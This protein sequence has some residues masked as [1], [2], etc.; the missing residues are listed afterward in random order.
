[1]GDTD[2]Y[3]VGIS[4]SKEKI[5]VSIFGV[6]TSEIKQ[7]SG[8][9]VWDT[10]KA[11]CSNQFVEVRT[12]HTDR[13]AFYDWELWLDEVSVNDAVIKEG[14]YLIFLYYSKY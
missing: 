7:D 2:T 10:C 8:I 14:S 6:D 12:H 4:D 1:M 3:R 5:N 9:A 11:R 13:Y